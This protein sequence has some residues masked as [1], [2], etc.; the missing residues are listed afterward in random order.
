MNK[1]FSIDIVGGGSSGWMTAI[2]L[3]QLMNHSEHNADIRVIESEDIGVIG[4]GEAT[5]HSIRYFLRAMGLDEHELMSETNATFK[6]GIKFR[7]W[8]APTDGETHEYFHPFEQ[9][10]SSSTLDLTTAWLFS[11]RSDTYAAAT[12]LSVPLV[13]HNRTPKLADMNQYQGVVPYG[14]H[15][16]AVLL[17]RYLRKI[18]VKRGVEHIVTTITEVVTNNKGIHYVADGTRKF[19]AD[20]FIDCTGFRGTLIEALD[21]DNWQSFQDALPCDRAVAIQ[22]PRNDD[23][24]P[25]NHTVATALSNG[26]AWQIDLTNR[27]GAGYVYDGN[28][29]TE[30]EAEKELRKFINTKGANV[31]ATHLKMKV[32]CR[33]RF[34]IGNTVAIGLSGGFIEPLEST[35]LHLINMGVALLGSSIGRDGVQEPI[36]Q[37]YNEL[38]NGF[39]ED[40]KRFV[41]LHYCLTDRNDTDFWRNAKATFAHSKGLPELLEIWQLKVCEHLD[42]AGTYGTTFNDENYRYVLFGMNFEPSIMRLHN[43]FDSHKALHSVKKKAAELVRVTIPVSRYC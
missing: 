30:E 27:Q 20:Y 29:L 36:R 6:L 5:V 40:L 16:D 18:A 23:Y 12:S 3:H 11:D 9:A 19:K 4:V 33:K 31:K 37:K 34:W 43:P 26:W 35:G 13:N 7:N 39:Y 42:L 2:Y 28:R 17:G 10:Y 24:E 25:N 1:P 32:G 14:Y 22:V 41:V 21:S 38:M 8:M 15:L